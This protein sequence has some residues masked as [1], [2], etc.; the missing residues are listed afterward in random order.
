MSCRKAKDAAATTFLKEAIPSTVASDEGTEE[1]PVA[2]ECVPIVSVEAAVFPEDGEMA[3][4]SVE[5]PERMSKGS[6]LIDVQVNDE[7]EES[8]TNQK[9][10]ASDTTTLANDVDKIVISSDATLVIIGK[11]D[12][13]GADEA[14]KTE[15]AAKA[16]PTMEEMKKAYENSACDC[17]TSSMF[18]HRRKKCATNKIVFGV[19]AVAVL[20]VGLAA[21]AMV[22]HDVGKEAGKEEAHEE[23]KER[24]A[25]LDAQEADLAQREEV[26]R[27]AFLDLCQQQEKLEQQELELVQREE[28]LARKENRV[29]AKLK[30]ISAIK[31]RPLRDV[32]F[33]LDTSGSMR[34]RKSEEMFH[35]LCE[36]L[37]GLDAEDGVSLI[38][39]NNQPYKVIGLAKRK[40]IDFPNCVGVCLFQ[41]KATKN[42]SFWCTGSTALWDAVGDAMETLIRRPNKRTQPHLVIVT[43]GG[44]CGSRRESF[45]SISSKLS[46]PEAVSPSLANLRTSYVSIG[47]PR[48]PFE[49]V[50][51]KDSQMK[52]FNVS[53]AH[54]IRDT[55][56]SATSDLLS[57]KP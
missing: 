52:Y 31:S 45:A 42:L 11:K 15:T 40:R 49:K 55:L 22:G 16:A 18:P 48:N 5:G 13:P 54:Q 2:L 7:S 20:G 9:S 14:R 8:V 38:L 35:A 50:S 56:K 19:G 53:T 44:D 29:D 32:V 21:G 33:V 39:F 23:L 1:M 36:V 17:V 3:D 24:S 41:N 47:R 4:E 27:K 43:D 6:E 34:G 28:E 10:L 46:D 57:N 37:L 30:A 26:M 12:S 51:M 25:E